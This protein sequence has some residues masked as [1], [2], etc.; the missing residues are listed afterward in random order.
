[1]SSPYS[2]RPPSPPTEIPP[3][4][5]RALHILFESQEKLTGKTGP[6][7]SATGAA[8]RYDNRFR[9]QGTSSCHHPLPY[10]YFQVERRRL[11]IQ[12]ERRQRDRVVASRLANYVPEQFDTY[13]PPSIAGPWV[14]VVPPP[15]GTVIIDDSSLAQA[16]AKAKKRRAEDDATSSNS[17]GPSGRPGPR[18]KSRNRW[19]SFNPRNSARS[20]NAPETSLAEM[21][22]L[23]P[24]SPPSW[25]H[26]ATAAEDE[27]EPLDDSSADDVDQVEVP[28]KA[29]PV[30]PLP[31]SQWRPDDP[32]PSAPH[33]SLDETH[34]YRFQR[35]LHGHE[36]YADTT[37][38]LINLSVAF[39]ETDPTPYEAPFVG[40]TCGEPTFR[41]LRPKTVV[42]TEDTTTSTDPPDAGEW[43][44]RFGRLIDPKLNKT[45][46]PGL[47]RHEL[48]LPSGDLLHAMN[49]AISE[50]ICKTNQTKLTKA[51]APTAL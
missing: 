14:D 5:R 9:S 19:S 43:D 22:T 11:Q 25:A 30:T 33:S 51:L 23:A 26:L 4:P 35:T 50:Y 34:P 44:A 6:F 8:V 24:E 16:L 18:S 46:P 3:I 31:D 12:G 20:H 40:G 49:G 21:D 17:M 36:H 13:G 10:I 15:A 45:L 38:R 27:D 39:S 28:I 2:S 7:N 29:E 41:I 47:F 37:G 42:K 32:A 1:M 48:P